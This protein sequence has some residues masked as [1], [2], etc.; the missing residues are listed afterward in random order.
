MSAA[1]LATCLILSVGR[2]A[3]AAQG[4]TSVVVVPPVVSGNEA[5][6]QA[7]AAMLSDRLAEHLG[8]MASAR[9]VDR[10]QIDRVLRERATRCDGNALIVLVC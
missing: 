5:S 8:A 7:A 3:L 4:P 10:T 1:L 6:R 9:V 2:P